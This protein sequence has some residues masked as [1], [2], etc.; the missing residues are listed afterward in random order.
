MSPS[1][2]T[3]LLPF[4]PLLPPS[5][6]FFKRKDKGPSIPLPPDEVARPASSQSRNPDAARAELFGSSSSSASPASDP[7]ARRP[8]S[9]APSYASQDPYASKAPRSVESVRA[10]SDP[11]R[12]ALFAGYN[13]DAI[14]KQQGRRQYGERGQD[15]GGDGYGGQQTQAQE[16]E[17][18]DVESIKRDIRGVK[19]ESLGSTRSVQARCGEG[20]RRCEL[21][22]SGAS[23]SWKWTGHTSS[24]RPA[25]SRT[26][27]QGGHSRAFMHRTKLEPRRRFWGSRSFPLP[28]APAYPSS[29]PPRTTAPSDQSLTQ[30]ASLLSNP[31]PH[32]GRNALRIAREAEET[33]RG[34][35]GRLG[36]QSGESHLRP[37][38]APFSLPVSIVPY[39]R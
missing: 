22:S 15:G 34:T 16:D 32:H 27:P 38:P 31:A 14:P 28:S 2:P 17:D 6:S 23:G 25:S 24:T 36:D 37:P 20:G 5:M 19:Q 1:R 11:A 12:A 3:T 39:Y 26:S 10:E 8:Q 18:E 29:E 13:P 4:L 7:Y 30:H 21:M 35:L 33:A 9:T